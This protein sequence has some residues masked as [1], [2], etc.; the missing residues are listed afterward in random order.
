MVVGY[1]L[2]GGVAVLFLIKLV[3]KELGLLKGLKAYQACRCWSLAALALLRPVGESPARCIPRRTRSSN[4]STWC[5]A[6]STVRLTYFSSAD[7]GSSSTCPT[8]WT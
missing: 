6:S 8:M 5:R 4:T 3:G 1:S 2:G 7:Q